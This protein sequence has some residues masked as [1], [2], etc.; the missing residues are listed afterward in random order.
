MF[1]LHGFAIEMRQM[2]EAQVR[3]TQRSRLE[4]PRLWRR[5]RAAFWLGALSKSSQWRGFVFFQSELRSLFYERPLCFV[6]GF[7]V[8]VDFLSG[9]AFEP[10]PTAPI[11][12]FHSL[13]ADRAGTV[14]NEVGEVHSITLY[15]GFV[16]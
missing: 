16:R 1:S 5:G 4:M 3:S 7:A 14:G 11:S 15:L 8:L 2:R 6:R 10:T 9:F 12:D 13:L